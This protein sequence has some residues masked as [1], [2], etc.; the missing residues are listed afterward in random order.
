MPINNGREELDPAVLR[1]IGHDQL[2]S[3]NYMR[4]V[5]SAA[6][7]TEIAMATECYLDKLGA[8]VFVEYPL[9]N[10][11]EFISVERPTTAV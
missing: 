1:P 7:V 4:F 9:L 2:N 11:V 6:S 5:N 10:T 3:E 8:T